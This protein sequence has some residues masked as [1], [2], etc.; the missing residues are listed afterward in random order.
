MSPSPFLVQDEPE[1][2]ETHQ[3]LDKDC[4]FRDYL[5]SEEAVFRGFS[6]FFRIL[7]GIGSL[8]KQPLL[9]N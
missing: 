9:P 4:T 2:T 8:Q 3:L 1:T 6:S 7:E 5:I